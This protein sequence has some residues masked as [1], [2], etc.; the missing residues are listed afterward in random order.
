[1]KTMD[2]RPRFVPARRFVVRMKKRNRLHNGCLPIVFL[3]QLLA[4]NSVWALPVTQQ[5]LQIVVTEGSGAKNVTEQIAARPLTVRIQ[6][7][8]N[9]PVAGATV[10]FTAPQT[11]PS[12]EFANDSRIVQVMTGADGVAS[13]GPFHPNG[14]EGTYQI[15]VRAEYQRQT[16][17]ATILQTN[18][19]K[20]GGHKKL[21][22]ILAIAGAAAG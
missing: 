14:I 18:I 22:A 2:N 10:I 12:G 6:D 15:V 20:G 1:M 9:R 17:S 3:C 21:I 7:A 5:G 13:A 8:N 4:F 19:S 16:T 11:G